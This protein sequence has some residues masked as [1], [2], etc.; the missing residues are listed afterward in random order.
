MSFFKQLVFDEEG[1]KN[2]NCLLLASAC[3]DNLGK[4]DKAIDTIYKV[5]KLDSKNPTAW[6]VSAFEYLWLF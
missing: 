5:L 2:I 4:E 3:Y 6:Q 1:D